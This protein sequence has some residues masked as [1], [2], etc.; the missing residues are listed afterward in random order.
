VVAVFVLFKRMG[1]LE[2]A[3]VPSPGDVELPIGATEPART[4]RQ[5]TRKLGQILRRLQWV[6][7]RCDV[8]AALRRSAN[9]GMSAVYGV[10]TR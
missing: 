2:D 3:E 7:D 6:L 1:D 9:Q 4:F 5:E 8:C 10:E